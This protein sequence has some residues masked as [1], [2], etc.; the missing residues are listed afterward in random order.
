M[1]TMPLLAVILGVN[2]TSEVTIGE[3]IAIAISLLGGVV[4]IVI[5]IRKKTEPSRMYDLSFLDGSS[6]SFPPGYVYN[7]AF[8]KKI[9][10]KSETD[11]LAVMLV[12]IRARQGVD[13]ESIGFRLVNRRWFPSRPNP[14]PLWMWQGVRPSTEGVFV[15]NLWDAE[16]EREQSINHFRLTRG[17]PHALADESGGYRLSFCQGKL[18]MLARDSLWI[19]VIVDVSNNWAGHLEFQGPS[20]DQQRAYTRRSVVIVLKAGT[21]DFQS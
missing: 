2:F 17:Q 18:R 21:E 6:G 16:W 12:R 11:G 10:A 5:G 1:I 19:R 9:T 3:M 13:I 8:S 15:T 14:F 7:Q 4:I 20:Q